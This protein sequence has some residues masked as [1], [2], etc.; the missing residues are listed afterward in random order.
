MYLLLTVRFSGHN[1]E[2]F[3]NRGGR[4]FYYHLQ[5]LFV[6]LFSLFLSISPTFRSVRGRG[7]EKTRV[8]GKKGQEAFWIW[9]NIR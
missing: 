9:I 7:G 1:L 8:K 5:G 2:Q 3:P 4:S 6:I